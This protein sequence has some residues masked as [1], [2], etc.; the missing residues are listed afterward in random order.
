MIYV[1]FEQGEVKS[2]RFTITNLKRPFQ[3]IVHTEKS[4]IEKK[5]PWETFI[6]NNSLLKSP[7]SYHIPIRANTYG[8]LFRASF[9]QFPSHWVYDTNKSLSPLFRDKVLHKIL[10][11]NLLKEDETSEGIRQHLQIIIN[12]LAKSYDFDVIL[13][14]IKNLASFTLPIP[15]IYD[16]AKLVSIPTPSSVRLRTI[17]AI[18]RKHKTELPL[19]AFDWQLLKDVSLTRH[20]TFDL[21][22]LKPYTNVLVVVGTNVYYA[23]F[24]AME[25]RRIKGEV[26]DPLPVTLFNVVG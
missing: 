21:K 23:G 9:Q 7:L 22:Q 11:E 6:K 18:L 3:N 1:T 16:N 5:K 4:V 14:D 8:T 26:F 15:I 24:L 19:R 20:S 2:N 13:T 10:H 17:Q 12:L 25:L